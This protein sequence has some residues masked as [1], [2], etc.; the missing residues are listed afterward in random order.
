MFNF[1]L[2]PI[3]SSH[4]ATLTKQA[5]KK[6]LGETYCFGLRLYLSVYLHIHMFVWPLSDIYSPQ[7]ITCMHRL[8]WLIYWF[9]DLSLC[10]LCCRQEA[11]QAAICEKDANIA[12]LEMT[13]TKKQ[14]NMEEI[15]KLSRE[16]DKL[17]QQ[18]KEL[19]TVAYI[20]THLCYY[21]SYCQYLDIYMGG[22]ISSSN[23]SH[24]P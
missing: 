4:K 11:L 20:I 19:V 12:L 8:S 5:R 22:C 18:L 2:M 7:G 13:S 23:N 17:N 9:Q 21:L 3:N 14:R 15:D 6:L 1:P 24:L 10:L 16:K